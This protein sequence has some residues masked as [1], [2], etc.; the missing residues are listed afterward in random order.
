[1]KSILIAVVL[2]TAFVTGSSS[3]WGQSASLV[4]NGDF[5][6]GSKGWG[7]TV[8]R[9]LLAV[10]DSKDAPVGSVG[11]PAKCVRLAITPVEGDVPWKAHFAQTI[12]TA[13]TANQTVEVKLWLRSPQNLKVNV[14]VEELSEGNPKFVRLT[15]KVLTP[16]WTEYTV[17][18]AVPRDL[19]AGQSKFIIHLGNVAGIVEV[20]GVRVSVK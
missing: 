5:T 9:V 10:E 16:A 11:F 3:A 19:P 2:L 7:A 4:T 12:Q 8:D 17:E 18:G 6:E 13:L 15:G 1:M 14:Y 20:A